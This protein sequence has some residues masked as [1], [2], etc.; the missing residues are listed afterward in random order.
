MG[1]I[2]SRGIQWANLATYDNVPWISLLSMATGLIIF[3]IEAAKT[4]E[5]SIH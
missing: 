3:A 1:V 4:K 5:F 2:H